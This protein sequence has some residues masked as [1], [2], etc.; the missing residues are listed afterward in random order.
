MDSKDGTQSESQIR[1]SEL[2]QRQAW[3]C[4]RCGSEGVI[5]YKPDSGCYEVFCAIRNA[6]AAKAPTCG[7]YSKIRVPL[8]A[9][10]ELPPT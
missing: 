4:E 5:E 9:P 10:H 8:N 2:V 6:H 3:N 7:D 1:S